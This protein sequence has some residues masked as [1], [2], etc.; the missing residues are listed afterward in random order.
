MSG[1][2]FEAYQLLDRTKGEMQLYDQRNNKAQVI[3][4]GGCTPETLKMYR[5]EFGKEYRE[6]CRGFAAERKR[7]IGEKRASY[8]IRW[9]RT[10]DKSLWS[11]ASTTSQNL[12]FESRYN[13]L[14]CARPLDF[15]RLSIILELEGQKRSF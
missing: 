15:P 2:G 14:G 4:G 10:L 13:G 11:K 1:S 8:V 12:P 5:D 7:Y 9:S 3:Q 6:Q